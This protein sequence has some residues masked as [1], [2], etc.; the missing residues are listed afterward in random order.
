MYALKMRYAG[1]FTMKDTGDNYRQG[2][3]ILIMKRF[4]YAIN[5]RKLGIILKIVSKHGKKRRRGYIMP[6]TSPELRRQ[7]GKLIA[8]TLIDNNMNLT[9]T[10]RKLGILPQSVQVSVKN[11]PYVKHYLDKFYKELEKA[12]ATDEKA[13]RVISEGMDA[14]IE[15]Y[16]KDGELLNEKEDHSI[17]LKSVELMAKIKRYIGD[18]NDVSRETNVGTQN[19]QIVFG[20]SG[21]N[22]RDL[23]D[24]AKSS[25]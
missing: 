5:A 20:D 16:S 4:G 21:K 10:G 22:I 25:L 13:A 14:K 6:R 3:E 15:V 23:D 8:K 2:L 1:L 9:R 18:S 24:D 7:K 11:N 12:G 19:I 17:R